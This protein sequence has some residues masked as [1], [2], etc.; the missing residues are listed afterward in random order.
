MSLVLW[1]LAAL[2]AGVITEE[3]LGW[4]TPACR[5]II[6]LGARQLPDDSRD[7]YVEEWYAELLELPQGALTRLVWTVRTLIGVRS[8]R[9]TLLEPSPEKNETDPGIADVA[10]RQAIAWPS[11][12]RQPTVLRIALGAELR[13]LRIASGISRADAGWAI[14]AS[15]SKISRLENGRVG[16]KQRDVVDLLTLYGITDQ[17]TIESFGRLVMQAEQTGWW[18]QSADQLPS[19]LPAYVSLEASASLIRLYSTSHIPDLLQTPDYARATLQLGLGTRP[20]GELERS[21]ELRVQR[22]KSLTRQDQPVRLWAI[23]DEA[24]L[25]RPFG[26][27]TVMR[28]QLEHLIMLSQ[29]PNVTIQVLPFSCGGSMTEAF[30]LLQYPHTDLPNVVHLEQR[31]SSLYLD[32]PSD[33]DYYRTL[34]DGLGVQAPAPGKTRDILSTILTFFDA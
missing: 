25:R 21:V 12:A 34:M 4:I 30:T 23:L 2:A 13:Q 29:Q 9:S 3:F 31:T 33:V 7:R 27:V 15:E 6:R 22:Q 17:V 28:A 5:F 19:G 1:A 14:R 20:S 26:G 8:I 32:D 24:A 18:H 16:I 11:P 10:L